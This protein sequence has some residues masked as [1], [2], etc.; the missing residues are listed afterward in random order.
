[1]KLIKKMSKMIECE[2]EDAGKYAK[3]ALKYK[4]DMPELARLFYTLST[5]EMEH[6]NKLHKAVV[7]IIEQ[8]RKENGEPPTA[9]MAVYEYLHDKQIE[10]AAEVKILQGMFKE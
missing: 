5:E 8:Y 7:E 1:M 6:M 4:E 9:M 3:C 10:E 2:I